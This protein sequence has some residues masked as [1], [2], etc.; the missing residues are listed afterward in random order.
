MIHFTVPGAA[1]PQGSKRHLG[2]GVMIESSKRVKPWRSDVRDAAERAMLIGV[3]RMNIARPAAPL[4]VPVRVEVVFRYRRPASHFRTD[5]VSLSATGRRSPYPMRGDIDKLCRALFDAMTGVVYVDDRQVVEVI[6][7]RVYGGRDE[8]EV[9]V[10]A[11]P[12][13]GEV[14]A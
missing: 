9:R 4:S 11:A 6:A 12:V 8:A 13:L 2:N 7:T 5:G 14:A 1:A 10:E 3:P